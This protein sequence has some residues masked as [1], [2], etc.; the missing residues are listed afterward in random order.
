MN[1]AGSWKNIAF[2]SMNGM[3][4]IDFVPPLQGGGIILAS[5][6]GRCPGLSCFAPLALGCEQF[7][8]PKVTPHARLYSL[9]LE[10]L[11][12]P[13]EDIPALKAL[14]MTAQG[15]A[16]GTRIQTNPKP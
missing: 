11:S 3:C 15:N 9:A 2:N 5:N 14:H 1:F 13:S 7:V 4:G 8:R 16:L 12:A 6:P 10:F